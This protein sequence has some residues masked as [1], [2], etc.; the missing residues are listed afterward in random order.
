MWTLRIVRT[1]PKKKERNEDLD[2]SYTTGGSRRTD[3]TQSTS[4]PFG[5]AVLFTVNLISDAMMPS[6]DIPSPPARPIW[7]AL[8]ELSTRTGNCGVLR[9]WLICISMASRVAR[10]AVLEPH[11]VRWIAIRNFYFFPQE[12]Q[13]SSLNIVS[14]YLNKKFPASDWFFPIWWK[15]YSKPSPIEHL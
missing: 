7:P 1:L 3:P 4:L 11:W 6:P 12:N 8:G 10:I 9:A 14:R 2:V 15:K 5:W 13:T